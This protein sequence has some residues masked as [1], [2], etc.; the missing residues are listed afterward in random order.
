M[1]RPG[2][3]ERSSEAKSNVCEI[4]SA[5]IVSPFQMINVS[6]GFIRNGPRFVDNLVENLK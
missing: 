6:A 5:F 3:L 1:R 2:D 4:E